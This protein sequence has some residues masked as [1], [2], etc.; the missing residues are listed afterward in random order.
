MAQLY[1]RET[2]ELHTLGAFDLVNLR[3]DLADDVGV[4]RAPRHSRK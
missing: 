2:R 3:R 1:F 4:S